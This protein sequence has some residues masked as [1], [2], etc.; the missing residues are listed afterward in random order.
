MN[1]YVRW[2][3]LLY[4]STLSPL[5]PLLHVSISLSS[6]LYPPI[7]PFLPP[8]TGRGSGEVQISDCWHDNDIKAVRSLHH[9]QS[10]ERERARETPTVYVQM[11]AKANTSEVL[12]VWTS[13]VCCMCVCVCVCQ[14]YHREHTCTQTCQH[15][16]T[17]LSWQHAHISPKNTTTDPTDLD[18]ERHHIS[19]LHLSACEYW[20]HTQTHTLKI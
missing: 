12:T 11:L 10:S 14:S 8:R 1:S 16:L 18:Q 17:S 19:G 2:Q 9:L 6:I 13:S 3:Q 7:P 4:L 20:T 5:H 15:H